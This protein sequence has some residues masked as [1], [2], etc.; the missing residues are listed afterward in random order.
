M[1]Q[2]SFN[3]T[4]KWTSKKGGNRTIEW[5]VV[6]NRIGISARN[7]SRKK[8][9]AELVRDNLG[10]PWHDKIRQVSENLWILED[11]MI[12]LKIKTFAKILE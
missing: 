7:Y 1:Q 10:G 12:H 8:A 11:L 5:K 6:L 9:V 4:K 2:R 3:P